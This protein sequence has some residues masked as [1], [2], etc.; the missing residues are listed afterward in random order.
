MEVSI[1]LS[2][3][4]KKKQYMISS[5]AFELLKKIS[6]GTNFI[7]L[8]HFLQ[9]DNVHS[10]YEFWK[11]NTATRSQKLNVSNEPRHSRITSM[12]PSLSFQQLF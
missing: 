10:F 6:S 1:N 12:S 4:N 3:L 5:M 8:T 7:I 9:Q 2:P 11:L